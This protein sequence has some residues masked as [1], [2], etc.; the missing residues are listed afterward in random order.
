MPVV[1]Q[2]WPVSYAF[3]AS[4]FDPDQFTSC[5]NLIWSIPFIGPGELTISA[6]I[7]AV[8]HYQ[9]QRGQWPWTSSRVILRARHRLRHCCAGWSLPQVYCLM[10]QKGRDWQLILR[11]VEEIISLG[12]IMLLLY[13]NHIYFL[14]LQITRHCFPEVWGQF[15]DS[16]RLPDMSWSL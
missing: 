5:S 7:C 14:D 9:K 11:C 12:L 4:N 15:K 1:I 8:R 10:L 16:T 6:G 3:L 13:A 2:N